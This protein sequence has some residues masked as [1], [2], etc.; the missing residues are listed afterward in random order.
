MKKI[1]VKALALLLAVAMLAGLVGCTTTPAPTEP[2]GTGE[3]PTTT[4]P[5]ETTPEAPALSITE[6][7]TY[8]KPLTNVPEVP[9]WFPAQLLEWNPAEDTEAAYNVSSIPLAQRVD[10]QSLTTVNPTQ[11]KDMNVVAISIMNASTSGNAP[12]GLN[13]ASS[14]VFSYWQYIDTLVY[15][16]GSSGEGLIVTPSADV[17]DA[18]HR[19]GVPVL[20]TVFFPQ[21]GH[22]GK[23]EWLND[24]LQKDADGNFPMVA[25]LI[26]VAEYFGFEGWF[27]NQE[28]EGTEDAPLTAEHAVLMQEFIKAF[29]AQAGNLTIMW[30]DSMTS[31]G[32]MDWQ[33]ALTDE[34]KFFIIGDDQ[35]AVADS[36]FL[37]FWWTNDSLA[38]ED[39]LK[40]SNEKAAELGVDPYTLYAGIDVQANGYNTP[41]RWN[42]FAADGQAPYTSLGLYCPSWTYFSASNF[43]TDYQERENMFWVNEEGDP[44]VATAA[45]DTDW[46]GIS[47]YAVEQ[48]V[49]NQIPFITNMSMGHGYAFFIDGQ[50]VSEKDWNNRSMQDVLPTYRW[51]IEQAEGSTVEGIMD[52]S[53]AWYG[54]TSMKLVGGYVA[55]EPVNATLYSSQ[56]TMNKDLSFTMKAKATFGATLNLL[57]TLD[58]GTTETINGDQAV[59]AEW[60]NVTFDVSGLDGKTVTAFGIQVISSESIIGGKFFLGQIAITDANSGNLGEVADLTVDGTSFDDDD[61][62]YSGVR[63][64][65]T[66]NGA[67]DI[68]EIYRVNQDGSRSFL[69]ATPSTNYYINGLERNDDTNKTNFVVVPVSATGERGNASNVA[70]MDWPNNSLPKADFKA[71]ATL[72]APGQEITFESLCSANTETLAWEFPG[73]SVETSSDAAPVVSYAEEGVYTVKL[74][75][76]NADGEAVAEKVGLIT[77]SS[78][79]TGELPL[80]SQGKDTSATAYVNENEAPPF[81]VDGDVTK[82]WC[83]TG[84]PPHEITIDLGAVQTISQV[85]IS[86]AEAG[87]EGADMNTKAYA[88]L[89]SEDGE[90]FTEVVRVTKN[91]DGVTVDTFAAVSARYVKLSVEKPTQGSDTAA[92][93]Y[94]IEVYGLE[95]G[96]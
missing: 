58:D 54:G 29:K 40:A 75:A 3:V 62:I 86:H 24:F 14:N 47:T 32:E 2:S 93:I 31:S 73:A 4:A 37:N 66:A 22:G 68:Y 92:R 60:T 5:Q 38:E 19:N 72:V 88:I 12:H 41:I 78:K 79:V 1:T 51:H 26:E 49:V 50:K 95:G 39:L 20:G 9:Y 16:G 46:R 64:S 6:E 27:I 25:K 63:L 35:E 59:G 83:A 74:T 44:F 65:W 69:I 76:Q 17:I 80:L 85:R 57:V 84:T 71:S 7:N 48:T 90:N 89:V 23:I 28:T 55:N 34:N 87:G 70:T 10:K 15:W 53:D 33:N 61:C 36:M 52:Y 91:S 42:L 8:S 30:Y 67:S 11:N 94:E 56:L 81:A 13:T 96:L 82:K 43:F 21:A 18:A 77:V 45:T